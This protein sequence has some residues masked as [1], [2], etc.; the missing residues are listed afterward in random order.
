M[1][2]VVKVA[3]TVFV[4][5][6]LAG[7][8]DIN[9]QLYYRPSL[10]S[11]QGAFINN[12]LRSQLTFLKHSLDD[13]S[14][15]EMQALFPEGFV[16]MNA[17]YG[18]TWCDFASVLQ[19]DHYLKNEAIAEV[20][21][22]YTQIN[23]DKARSIFNEYLLI[24]YGAFYKGWNNYLLAKK[25]ALENPKYKPSADIFLFKKQCAEIAQVMDRGDVTMFPSSYS[26]GAWPADMIVCVA[27]LALHDQMFDPMYT[28]TIER[29][30]SRVKTNLDEHGL[31]PHS[32]HPTSGKIQEAARGSSQS[33]ILIF[34]ADID[35]VFS[36]QQ[37][38]IYK[39][40]FLDYRFGLPGVRE[41]PKGTFGLGDVDSGPVIFQMGGAATIVASR[42]M[43]VYNE[44]EI[45]FALR[46]SV[47]AFGF[48][49]GRN[50]KK[51]LLGMLPMAD[52][53]IAWSRSSENQSVP[54]A[55]ID[56]TWRRHF[57]LYSLLIAIPFVL[58]IF[59]IWRF[60]LRK[61]IGK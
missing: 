48:P 44:F 11:T 10:A 21:K 33:L 18:L 51:Y 58:L 36:R 54:D 30:L 13:G 27:S 43:Q 2:K 55:V 26:T 17:L 3:V 22:A 60:G 29:W 24:P 28:Q 25:I 50:E 14:A 1:R 6:L 57:H 8:V 52:A 40:L 38:E 34:L 9:R 61:W 56:F 37:F 15:D 19:A 16:F 4:F 23:S 20:T 46:N 42:T 45:A 35:P 5:L 39:E 47:E 32:V 31:I 7:L 53:F 12:D 41:Y 49:F 59:V